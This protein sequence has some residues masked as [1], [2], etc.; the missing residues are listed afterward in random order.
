MR[1][2][3]CILV[4]I[5]YFGRLVIQKATIGVLIGLVAK[6]I[7]VKTIMTEDLV[8]EQLTLIRIICIGI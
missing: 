4:D 2:K 1:I 6:V 8:V 3:F 5:V 7:T